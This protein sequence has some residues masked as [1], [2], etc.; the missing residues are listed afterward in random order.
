MAPGASV[1]TNPPPP[2]PPVSSPGQG[3]APTIS[4]TSGPVPAYPE[5]ISERMGTVG[6]IVVGAVAATI[7]AVIWAIITRLTGYQIGFMAIGIGILVGVAVRVASDQDGME[8]GLLGGA[9]SLF[10]VVLG[11]LLAACAFIASNNS[12]SFLQ[13]LME[14]SRIRIPS[15]G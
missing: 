5:T 14:V 15:A 10:G 12:E 6:V 4:T 7:G 1:S 9:L 3:D 11:N 8:I 2:P 13:V